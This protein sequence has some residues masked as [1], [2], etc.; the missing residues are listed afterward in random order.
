VPGKG[1]AVSDNKELFELY[2]QHAT[3]QEKY[4]YFLLAAAASAL[5]FAVQKTAGLTIN[6]WLLPAAVA[7]LFWGVSFFFGCKNLIWVQ[8]A[9]YANYNLLSLKR[10]VHPEQPPHPQ[11]AISGVEKALDSNAKKAQFYAKWQFRCLVLGGVFFLAWHVLE[12]Y[13]NT[14]W[15]LT[16]QSTRTRARVLCLASARGRATV[17]G[18]VRHLTHADHRL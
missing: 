6:W 1:T 16:A 10:G 7:A 11:L 5:A 4:T 3:G 8:T 14:L 13:R 18:N 12:M 17:T 15:Y 2:K 9:I